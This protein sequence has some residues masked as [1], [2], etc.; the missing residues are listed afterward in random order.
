MKLF[1]ASTIAIVVLVLSAS[2]AVA[3]TE[4]ISAPSASQ[5]LAKQELN[6]A[7]ASYVSGN[8]SEAQLHSERA[9]A[10]D[11]DNK[12]APMFIARTIHAQF[13]RGDTSD[14]NLLKGREAIVAYQRIFALNPKDDE[15]YKAIAYLYGALR[16]EQSRRD[17]IFRRASDTS[18]DAA[19]RSEAYVALASSEWDCSFKITELP[20]NKTVTAQNGR[21]VVRYSMTKDRSDFELAQTCAERGIEFIDM[22]IALVPANERGWS[23]KAN[24]LL[25]LEKL[26]EMEGDLNQKTARHSE[27]DLALQETKRLEAAEQEK[28]P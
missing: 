20:S 23:Y 7:A 9:L 11:P 22:A 3:Q 10:L 19:K 18:V 1:P 27:Y 15:A 12:I 17:W 5:L 4:T 6:Q 25:E 28:K 21:A 13:K 24:L 14:E 26:A 8:F 16:D 2:S